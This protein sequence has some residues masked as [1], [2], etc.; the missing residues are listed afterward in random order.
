MAKPFNF[1]EINLIAGEAT[2]SAVPDP[3]TPFCIAVLGDFSGRANRHICDPATIATRRAVLVDRDNFD[4]VMAKLAPEIR[5]PLGGTG[6]SFR[7]S[8]IDDFHP[9]QI[10]ERSPMFDRLRDLRFRLSNPVTF[11]ATADELGISFRAQ[12]KPREPEAVR[13]AAP[14]VSGLASGSLLDAMIAES[15][16]GAPT[17]HRE[18]RDEVQEFARRVS[19]THAVAAADPRQAEVVAVIDRA[20]AG[21]MRALLHVPDF[22]ALEAAWRAVLLLVRRIETNTQLKLYLVDVSQEELA[23]DLTS[24]TDLRATG[25]YRLLVERSVRTPG[26][27]PWTVLVGNYIFGPERED[28]ELLGKLAKVASAA[29]APFVAGASPRLLGCASLATTPE[30]RNC[31]PRAE[32]MESW[33]ALRGLREASSVGLVLPRF[34]LRLPYG[35]KTD[36]IESF[37]FEEMPGTPVHEDYLWGNSAFACCLL[38]AQSFS[39]EEWEMRPG[40]ISEIERLPLHV[41]DHDGESELKPCAE[42]LLTEDA[43]E[44]MLENGL[45]PLASLKGRDAARLVRFQSIAAPLRPLAGRWA[46]S[47]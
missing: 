30:P 34:L 39:E 15:E 44:Q 32:H 17:T 10:F 42:A 25:T 20:M 7:F 2:T 38:L 18:R 46:Y 1:G 45:M 9:D 11:A 47:H 35:K 28:V 23:A 14:D 31:K 29:G 13:P 43:A 3:E 37:D 27:E 41:Y 40:I 22:Q 8:T 4:Q 36:A 24:S 21:Q 33:A 12:S 5:L 16:S 6:L 26:A 19:E